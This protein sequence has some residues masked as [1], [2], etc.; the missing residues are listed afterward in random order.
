VLRGR[1]EW[2]A[3]AGED[4]RGVADEE[5]V[6]DEEGVREQ[7]EAERRAEGRARRGGRVARRPGEDV[8]GGERDEQRGEQERVE[9]QRQE[10]HDGALDGGGRGRGQG[11]DDIDAPTQPRNGCATRSRSSS[12]SHLGSM[13]DTYTVVARGVSF[14]LSK[15]QISFD[16]P[17]F[18]TAAFLGGFSEAESRSVSIDTHP[19]LF[20]IIVDYLS[21]YDVFPLSE[22][23]LPRRMDLTRATRYLAKDADYLGLSKLQALL[24]TRSVPAHF[25]EWAQVSSI[26]MTLEDLLDHPLPA[27]VLL[28]STGL[29][30]VRKERPMLSL[31]IH[32]RN[33]GFQ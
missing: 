2:K 24:S 20:E 3:E 15:A 19:E 1:G 11:D 32:A 28:S 27:D 5:G 17:N 21:G 31:V 25:L 8:E 9:R 29:Q 23:A 26:N 22:D 4:V 6:E 10:R 7:E 33:L 13:T 18:F 16:S 30:E 12:W 14:T